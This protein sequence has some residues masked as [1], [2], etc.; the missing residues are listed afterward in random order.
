MKPLPS[1]PQSHF[2]GSLTEAVANIGGSD[3]NRFRLTLKFR[4][5]TVPWSR[6]TR[7]MNI[8]SRL[9]RQAL[10]SVA[11]ERLAVSTWKCI[12]AGYACKRVV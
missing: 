12:P 9:R 8:T 2:I 3:P 5:V 11:A 6:E 4:S 10:P 1:P 7:S